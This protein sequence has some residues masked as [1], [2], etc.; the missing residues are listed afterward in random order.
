MSSIFYISTNFTKSPFDCQDG[1]GAGVFGGPL[2]FRFRI[3]EK[4]LSGRRLYPLYR[5]DSNEEIVV[6][7]FLQ[8]QH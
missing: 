6:Y 7:Y 8:Y 4:R 1:D 5:I 3:K 2:E